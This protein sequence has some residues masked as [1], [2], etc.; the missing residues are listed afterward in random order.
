MVLASEPVPRI[1]TRT[2]SSDGNHNIISFNRSHATR[3][4]ITR[5]ISDCWSTSNMCYGRSRACL[6]FRRHFVDSRTEKCEK[7]LANKHNNIFLTLTNGEGANEVHKTSQ[8]FTKTIR[9]KFETYEKLHLII[10]KKRNTFRVMSK[11]G[12]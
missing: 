11:K 4:N 6:D 3:H 7:S 1:I 5:L 2:D 8:S 10:P 12:F 9:D